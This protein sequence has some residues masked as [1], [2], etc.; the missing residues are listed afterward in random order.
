MCESQVLEKKPNDYG[1]LS[2]MVDLLRRAGKLTDASKYLTR[3]EANVA[4]TLSDPGFH[5]CKVCGFCVL[6]LVRLFLYF[7]L[8]VCV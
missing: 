6:V 5:Y 8:T 2:H 7:L 4:R 1:A 3:A